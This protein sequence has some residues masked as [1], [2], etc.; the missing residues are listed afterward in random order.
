[1]RGGSRN[2]ELKVDSMQQCKCD[3]SSI[4][5]QHP[6][7]GLRGTSICLLARDIFVRRLKGTARIA[8]V[9]DIGCAAAESS[10]YVHYTLCLIRIR[11]H[12]GMLLACFLVV[13][14]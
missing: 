13:C 9:E 2:N 1:M 11:P 8:H 4:P 6:Y 3:R 12:L 5:P 10:W 14:P 7:E